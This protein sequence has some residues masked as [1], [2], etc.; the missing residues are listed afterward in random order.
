MDSQLDQSVVSPEQRI[1]ELNKVDQVLRFYV[2]RA[3]YTNGTKNIVKMLKHMGL[4]IQ[5]MIGK[6]GVNLTLDERRAIFDSSVAEAFTLLA[7]IDVAQRRSIYALAEAGI[8]DS[9]ASQSA[10]S[11]TESSLMGNLDVSALNSQN[12]KV[13]KEIENEQWSK[14]REM[15]EKIQ[16]TGVC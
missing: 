11:K 12:D 16:E 14:M 8:I 5:A 3:D 10:A 9:G 1:L 4:A 13:G 15:L 2:C 7:A 6:E